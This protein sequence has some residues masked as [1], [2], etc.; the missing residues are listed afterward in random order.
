MYWNSLISTEFPDLVLLAIWWGRYY[1]THLRNEDI[2]EE[3]D[4]QQLVM[5]E[6]RS[7]PIQLQNLSSFCYAESSSQNMYN[8]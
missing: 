3:K 5:E 2:K 1:Y 7:N 4:I 6:W 8:K